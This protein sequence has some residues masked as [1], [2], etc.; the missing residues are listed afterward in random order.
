[1]LRAYAKYLRQ[2]WEHLLPGL[3]GGRAPQ[4]HPH[5]PVVLVNL[6]EARSAPATSRVRP[7]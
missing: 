2:A 1:M 6:F 5:H 4:Q 7:S 3:H